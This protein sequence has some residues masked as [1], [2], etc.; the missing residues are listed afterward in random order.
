MSAV[1]LGPGPSENYRNVIVYPE[2][3]S[4]CGASESGLENVIVRYGEV[5]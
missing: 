2:W 1:T 4:G 3:N 5:H